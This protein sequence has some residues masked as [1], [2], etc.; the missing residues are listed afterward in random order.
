[1]TL[2][3]SWCVYHL[4]AG[5]SPVDSAVEVLVD[6]GH[7]AAPRGCVPL[8]ARDSDTDFCIEIQD[9]D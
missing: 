9:H 8:E 4:Q 3:R 1:M 7:T 5:K 6:I 2:T